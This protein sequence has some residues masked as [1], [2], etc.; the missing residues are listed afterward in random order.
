MRIVYVTDAFAV[1]G[2][3]ERVLADK[4]NYM[5]ENNDNMVS[6]ITINQGAHPYSFNLHQRVCYVDLEIRMHQQYKYHGIKRLIIRKELDKLLK[7]RM[8]V[9]IDEINPD[10][11]FCVKFDFVGVLLKVKR[12]ARL[13]VESHTLCRAEY[14]DGSGWLRRMH[15]HFYKK[16][17]ARADAIVTLTQGDA[18]EWRKITPYVY[19]IPNVVHL[20]DI[21][22]YSRCDQKSVIY[23]GRF[24]HQKDINSLLSVWKLVHIKHPDWKLNM[25][26]EGELRNEYINKIESL[27]T[28]IQ[29]FDPTPNMMQNYLNNSILILTSLYEPFGLVLPEAMSCGLPVVSFDSPYGP[30]EII[31]DGI[32]GFLIKGRNIEAFADKVCQLIEDDNLRQIIGSAAIQSAQRFAVDKIMPQWLR[33]LENT[34]RV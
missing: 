26:S 17:I 4:M 24:S 23:V 27:D 33:L 3:M 6:L 8:Q 22:T 29:V 15:I 5:A 10:V 16:N 2:G 9:V 20:N 14:F 13:I 12:N 28:N 30:E 19:V 1:L 18:S 11:I 31:T 32:D 21:G 34:K 7:K 25:Y